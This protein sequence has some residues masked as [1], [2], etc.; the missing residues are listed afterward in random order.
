MSAEENPSH[1]PILRPPATTVAQAA[2]KL[3]LFGAAIGL[4]FALAFVVVDHH[5]ANSV[6]PVFSQAR[7]IVLQYHAENG[8]WPKDFD[9]TQPG[10]D[11]AGYRL[12]PLAEALGRCEL[13]GRWAFVAK[14]PDGAP[15]LVFTPAEPGRR[16]ERTLGAVDGWID[17]GEALT[18]EMRVRADAASLRLSGE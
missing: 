3:G 18:G 5:R 15:A 7:T 17:D 6:A 14:G 8:A 4:T 13:P 11:F 1:T 12:A 2:T 9:V 10:P 16:Y